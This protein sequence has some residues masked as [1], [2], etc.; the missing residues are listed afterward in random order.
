MVNAWKRVGQNSGPEGSGLCVTG[1]MKFG[2]L[3]KEALTTALTATGQRGATAFGGHTSAESVLLFAAAFGG[4][5]GPFHEKEFLL[6]VARKEAEDAREV[7]GC[8][9]DWFYFVK[10]C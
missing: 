5:I 10:K 8:Q 9:T 1:E 2:T 6:R 7:P 3:R 4:L